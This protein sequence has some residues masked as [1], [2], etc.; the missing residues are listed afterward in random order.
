MHPHQPAVRIELHHYLR[1]GLH[2]APADRFASCAEALAELA[3]VCSGDMPVECRITFM[4]Q[5]HSRLERYMDAHPVR[6]MWIAGVVE[7]PGARPTGHRPRVYRVAAGQREAMSYRRSRASTRSSSESTRRA[8]SI[9]RVTDWPVI[10]T[11]S[12]MRR[13]TARIRPVA[14][15]MR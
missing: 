1:R 9:C 11:R 5:G 15:S 7:L 4:K 14:S 12:P 13:S 6:A 10:S 8:T 3:R 2:K